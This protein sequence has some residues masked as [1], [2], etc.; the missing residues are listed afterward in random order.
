MKGNVWLRF[1]APFI[2][3]A[4]FIIFLVHLYNGS[5]SCSF[6]K[7]VELVSSDTYSSADGTYQYA[8]EQ[9]S[10]NTDDPFQI[11]PV[12][13]W[14]VRKDSYYYK[15]VEAKLLLQAED[16]CYTVRLYTKKRAD[17]C[18]LD[19]SDPKS[20]DL[21]AGFFARFPVR[22]LEKGVYKIGLLVSENGAP[23]V[24]WMKDTLEVA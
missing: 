7:T 12:E 24:I 9:K 1:A 4:L 20:Q 14:L 13:G 3:Y 11:A 2:V 10:I 17:I 5:S 21:A 22:S 18:Y 19:Q 16:R 23:A 6:A 8:L 15:P